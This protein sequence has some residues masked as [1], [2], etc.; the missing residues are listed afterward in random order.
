MRYRL[1]LEG[2]GEFPN[3]NNDVRI[4]RL[5]EKNSRAF[6]QKL[7]DADG[8]CPICLEDFVNTQDM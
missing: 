3:V 7:G 4:K 5:L 6:D 2:R 8:T 1:S